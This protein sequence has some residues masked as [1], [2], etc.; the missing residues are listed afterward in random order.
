MKL[1]LEVLLNDKALIKKLKNKK[2][3]LVCHPASVNEKLEHSFDLLNKAIKLTAAFGPQHGS[4]GVTPRPTTRYQHTP[5][6]E[7][8]LLAGRERNRTGFREL[9]FSHP[10]PDRQRPPVWRLPRSG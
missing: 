9:S 8:A 6:S 4:Y 7:R 5:T 1:G 3:A 10:R 2:C